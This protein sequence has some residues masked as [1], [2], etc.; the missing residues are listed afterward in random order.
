MQPSAHEAYKK[1]INKLTRTAKR[2]YYHGYFAENSKRIK[3]VW[4][5][6]RQVI[7]G[8]NCRKSI[9]SII[10]NGEEVSDK[11]QIANLFNY[12]F[13]SI[14]SQLEDEIPTNNIHPQ[15]VRQCSLILRPL[16]SARI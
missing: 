2:N 1:S 11:S 4:G 5:K 7:G 10:S 6:I 3:K 12:Y 16:A 8:S 14:A 15:I 9:K 13:S